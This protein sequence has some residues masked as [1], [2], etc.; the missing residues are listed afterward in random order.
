MT[1]ILI[2]RGNL[3]TETD[4]HTGR[5]GCEMEAGPPLEPLEAASPADPLIL[6]CWPPEL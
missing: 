2:K 1:G 5:T 4:V 3:D 6:D